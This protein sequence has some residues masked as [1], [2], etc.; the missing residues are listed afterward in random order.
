[1]SADPIIV[2]GYLV[3]CPLG[4][5]AW[6][7]LHYLVGLRS[8]GFQPYFYEDN[9]RFSECFDPG[10]GEMTDEP[11]PGVAR[12]SEFFARTGFD[13]AWMFHDLVRE[14]SFGRTAEEQRSLIAQARVVI[15]LAGVNPL[16]ERRRHRFA[17]VDLDPGLTQVRATRGEAAVR[18]LLAQHDAHFTLGENIG[19]GGCAVPT[20]GITWHATRQPIAIELWEPVS[21]DDG[22]A[23]T[24]V[25]RW[26]ERRREVVLGEQ[27]YSWR[28][29]LEW[30][31]FLELPRRTGARFVVAMDVAKNP[32]DLELLRQHGWDV[33]DPLAVSSDPWRYR[34]FIR[35]SRGEFTV[36]KD[37][38]V[39]LS[40]G[41]FSDRGACYL[42][43]ARPVITQP[44][45]FEQPVARGAGLFQT[46][47]VEEATEAVRQVQENYPRHSQA[48]RQIAEYCFRADR[49]LADLLC[50]LG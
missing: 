7:I 9:A 22:A 35:N 43:A 4:G 16:P 20:A 28:K 36:A 45:G 5:Y 29:R 6:Q 41:W 46:R 27:T 44:T 11:G 14:R 18:E 8:L 38:N 39:R 47:D 49:V 42:A 48:A 26:D 25:G 24:T 31:K 3:R 17:F 50:V 34:D 30:M 32:P 15:D 1:V 12:V 10:T 23:F 13:E 21:A 40:T 2:S 19:R 33:V 37:L